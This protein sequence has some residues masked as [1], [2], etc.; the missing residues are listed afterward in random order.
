MFAR[1]VAE[2]AKVAVTTSDALPSYSSELKAT[3]TTHN[4][5]VLDA[6]K[7]GRGKKKQ[8]YSNGTITCYGYCNSYD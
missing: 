6:Y 3:G 5:R 7:M 1:H 8:Q 4:T 2:G